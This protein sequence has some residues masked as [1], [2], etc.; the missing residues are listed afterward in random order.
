MGEP[1]KKDFENPM[2]KK[3]QQKFDLIFKQSN[4]KHSD[5]NDTKSSVLGAEPDDN[6]EFDLAPSEDVHMATKKEMTTS[7]PTL[8]INFGD[9]EGGIEFENNAS[10]PSPVVSGKAEGAATLAIVPDDNDLGFSLDFGDDLLDLTPATSTQDPA[11]A[12]GMLDIP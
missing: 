12:K 11:S 8:D 7:A 10:P 9:D 5:S 1:I 2:N 6:F 4:G 3:I